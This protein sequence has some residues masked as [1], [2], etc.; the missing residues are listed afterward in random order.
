[1]ENWIV[2][3]TAWMDEKRRIDKAYQYAIRAEREHTAVH[4]AMM[5]FYEEVGRYHQFD[6]LTSDVE[7][8]A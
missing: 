6:K 1:M 2:R 3:I 8:R 4:R 5:T 7:R